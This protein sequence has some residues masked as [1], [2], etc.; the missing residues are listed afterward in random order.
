MDEARR[1]RLVGPTGDWEQLELLCLWPEQRD[2]ELIRPL[3]LF[4]SPPPSAQM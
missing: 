1:R 4:G 2:F 3:V